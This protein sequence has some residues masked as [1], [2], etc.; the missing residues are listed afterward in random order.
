MTSREGDQIMDHDKQHQHADDH[1]GA[2]AES[3]IDPICGMTVEKASA[4]YTS[5][6]QGG[7][8]YFCSDGCRVTFNKDPARALERASSAR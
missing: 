3:A 5:Q 7:T 8:Y 4:R 1:A 2:G 6:Y